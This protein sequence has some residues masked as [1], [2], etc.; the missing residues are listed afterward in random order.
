VG[1]RDTLTPPMFARQMVE[2]LPD[3]ELTVLPQAGHQLMQER[4]EAVAQLIRDLAVRSDG[5]AGV[6]AATGS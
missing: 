5:A 2:A 4:P 1:S 6:L 3:A